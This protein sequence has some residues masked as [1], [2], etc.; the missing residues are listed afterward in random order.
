MIMGRVLSRFPNAKIYTIPDADLAEI[1]VY[2]TISGISKE[3][4]NSIDLSGVQTPYCIEA[5]EIM[6]DGLYIGALEINEVTIKDTGAVE[7]T[8]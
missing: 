8:L 6:V 1:Q 4:V 2:F 5:E 7:V 3:D